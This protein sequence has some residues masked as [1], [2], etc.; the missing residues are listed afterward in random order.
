MDNKQKSQ[1]IRESH[2]D[3]ISFFRKKSIEKREKNEMC[4]QLRL[5]EFLK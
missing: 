2:F 4:L 5:S 3:L 1:F